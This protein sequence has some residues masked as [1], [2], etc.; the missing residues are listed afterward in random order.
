M[1]FVITFII[2]C[3]SFLYSSDYIYLEKNIG[4]LLNTSSIKTINDNV[5]I[6][7]HGG[8][9]SF[10]NNNY[11]VIGNLDA[12]NINNVS[13]DCFN[14]IWLSSLNEGIIQLLDEDLNL[15]NTISSPKFDHII[16]VYH[17]GLYSF[18]I[19]CNGDCFD[20]SGSSQYF[21]IEYNNDLTEPYYKDTIDNFSCSFNKINDIS[22]IDEYVY[23]ATDNCLVRNEIN[24]SP[25]SSWDSIDTGNFSL[26]EHNI[27]IKNN[28][29]IDIITGD[30]LFNE[31]NL[32][33]AGIIGEYINLYKF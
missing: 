10:T 24:H 9:Y 25:Y 7:S 15:I 8:V 31:A 19:G 26:I 4:S 5:L 17:S 12:I 18:A 13:V 21:I 6:A 11:S 33:A 28:S 3:S 2:F 27:G 20:E 14:H 16:S 30:E 1:S 29:I 32:I 22:F 23:I